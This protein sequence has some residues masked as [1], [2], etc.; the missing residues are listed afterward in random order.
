MSF[1][2]ASEFSDPKSRLLA[3]GTNL[4]SRNAITDPAGRVLAYAQTGG[5]LNPVRHELHAATRIFRFGG[6][7]RSPQAVAMGGWWIEQREFE[8]I[9]SFAQ[10]HDL[11]VGMAMRCLCLVPPEWSDASLLIR[12]RVV[13]DLLAWR[14]LGNTVVTPAGNGTVHLPHQNEIASRR[15]NQLF[16]PGLNEPGVAAMALVIESDYPLNPRDSVRGFLYL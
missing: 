2:N 5:I 15:L 9:V 7:G 16:I 6:S 4:S 8:K 1:L 13:R 10:T 3:M 12:A 14:G 11:S